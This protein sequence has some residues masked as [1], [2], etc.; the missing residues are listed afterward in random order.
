MLKITL[1]SRIRGKGYE[2]GLV[3]GK[4]VRV[5]DLKHCLHPKTK[6]A[7]LPLP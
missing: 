6:Q 5:N 3:K 2:A 1:E 4:W 7:S